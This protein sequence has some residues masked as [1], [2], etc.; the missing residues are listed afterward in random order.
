ML[1]PGTEIYKKQTFLSWLYERYGETPAHLYR[2]CDETGKV[3]DY[4][5]VMEWYQRRYRMIKQTRELLEEQNPFTTQ[6]EE[7]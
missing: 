4:Y 2:L 3:S 7:K 5:K 6:M 1:P